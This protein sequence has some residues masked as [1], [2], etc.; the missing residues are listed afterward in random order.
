MTSTEVAKPVFEGVN[1]LLIGNIDD[2][3]EE[4]LNDN[5]ATKDSYLTEMVTHVICDDIEQDEYA[6]AVDLFELPVVSS[7]WVTQSLKCG[8]ILPL[9]AFNLEKYRLFSGL[10]VCASQIALAD[11]KTLWAMVNYHGGVCTR[12]FNKTVTHLFCNKPSGAKYDHAM[13]LGESAIRIVTIDWA[14]DC[15]KSQT[16]KSEREYHPKLLILEKPKPPAPAAADV[17]LTVPMEITDDSINVSGV[18]DI[19]ESP[20]AGAKVALA[21]MVSN[22]MQAGGAVRM[23]DMTSKPMMQIPGIP[24]PISEIPKA[25]LRNIINSGQP[26]KSPI[27]SGTE[28]VKDLLA[29]LSQRKQQLMAG[30]QL[31]QGQNI[32]LT[33]TY[34]GHDPSDTVP[35]EL[36]LLGC[37]FYITDYQHIVKKNE[38]DVWK[39]VID[40]YGGQ[41]DASYSNR[42]THLLCANQKSDI[43][44]LAVN[45]GKR[46]VTAHWL[47]ACLTQKCMKPPWHVLHFPSIYGQNKPCS[48]QIIA[49]SKFSETERIQLKYMI[50]CI[51]ARYTSYMTATNSAL[52]CKKPSGS[53]YDKARDKRIPVLNV[54]W[55]NDL[56]MGH[57]EA[58]KL[59]IPPKYQQFALKDDFQV[60]IS[61]L[62]HLLKG[63]MQP[64]KI[65]KD[66]WKKFKSSS[67]N[68]SY[69]SAGIETAQ[70]AANKRKDADQLE[71]EPAAKRVKLSPTSELDSIIDKC[72]KEGQDEVHGNQPLILMTGINKTLLSDLVEKVEKLGGSI[73]NKAK[74]PTHL[75]ANE[76]V[77]TCKFLTA[78]SVVRHI[79]NTEWI[80]KSAEKGEFIDEVPFTLRDDK[81]EAMYSIDIPESLR[82]ARMRPLFKDMTF[83]IT[84]ST[85]PGKPLIR[86]IVISA[87]GTVVNRRPSVR[88]IAMQRTPRGFPA[89]IVIGCDNDRQLLIDM[90]HR[91]LPVYNA[92][93]VL[94]G[95]LRQELDYTLFH[96]KP[97]S[98]NAK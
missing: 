92:E 33:P 97:P 48:S 73:T 16:R 90:F 45:D 1:Y 26:P 87:G 65:S 72:I 51:G 20:Q 31:N 86:D 83:Y 70:T 77:R 95:V 46:V 7:K 35:P 49:I 85:D 50:S 6:E 42:I 24:M 38:I 89:F 5:G 81:A 94:T 69:P 80:E 82:R 2:K 25:A 14:H 22:R 41:V 75:V 15:V 62:H 37:V 59:P 40:Q 10:V 32:E 60:D 66:T 13:K 76:L 3:I 98:Q 18:F 93:F 78:I 88:A 36:C 68:T 84:P 11:Y 30:Q 54:Q 4:L 43:Y 19:E 74:C 57:L 9:E 63:W 79:V 56:V 71:D 67:S 29:S 28:K 91:R 47:N 8:C 12:K 44:Q 34:Y 27:R 17:S 53:K 39:T 64:L 21:K 55:L 23:T 96:M 58:L 61:R 52:I